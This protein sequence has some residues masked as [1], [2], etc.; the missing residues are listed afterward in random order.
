MWFLHREPTFWGW[1]CQVSFFFIVLLLHFGA[2]PKKILTMYRLCKTQVWQKGIRTFLKC[3]KEM[4]RRHPYCRHQIFG[5]R[6]KYILKIPVKM[7]KLW[8]FQ[9]TVHRSGPGA[10]RGGWWGGDF[11]WDRS[12]SL[13]GFNFFGNFD[14]ICSLQ[15]LY[16]Q[17]KI[18]GES[19]RQ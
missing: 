6:Q 8:Y 9:I 19:I 14:K 18:F 17:I 7:L 15:N 2:F 16:S 10:R 13:S 12:I 11:G 4:W 3:V 1:N 5:D